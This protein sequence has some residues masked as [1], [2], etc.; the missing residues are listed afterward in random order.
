LLA[1]E[2]LTVAQDLFQ[3]EKVAVALVQITPMERVK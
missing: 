2:L 1:V 3:V